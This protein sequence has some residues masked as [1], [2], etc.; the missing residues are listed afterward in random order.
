[1]KIEDYKDII[2]TDVYIGKQDGFLDDVNESLVNFG[3]NVWNVDDRK[4]Q[5]RIGTVNK[6]V[7]EFAEILDKF[8]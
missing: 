2:L 1:M 3:K 7:N 6:I 5:V 8:V 4:I